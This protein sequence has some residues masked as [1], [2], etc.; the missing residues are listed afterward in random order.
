MVKA[1]KNCASCNWS[2]RKN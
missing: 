1:D 2:I